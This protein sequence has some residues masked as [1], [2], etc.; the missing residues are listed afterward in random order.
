MYGGNERERNEF[1]AVFERQL[2]LP[3]LWRCPHVNAT[4]EAVCSA[5]LRHNHLTAESG[6]SRKSQ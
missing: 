2:S 4:R 3:R 1:G 6:F 5:S